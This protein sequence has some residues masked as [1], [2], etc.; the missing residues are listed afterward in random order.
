MIQIIVAAIV[1]VAFA[2]VVICGCNIAKRADEDAEKII[3][4]K[5]K[6]DNS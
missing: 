5:E 1:G 4:N 3:E 6:T 2:A